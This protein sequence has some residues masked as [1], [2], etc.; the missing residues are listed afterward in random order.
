MV[1]LFCSVFKKSSNSLQTFQY[2]YLVINNKGLF[3]EYG[4]G[5]QLS[6]YI[7]HIYVAYIKNFLAIKNGYSK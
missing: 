6:N 3:E 1:P 7:T 5:E 4:E 2:P